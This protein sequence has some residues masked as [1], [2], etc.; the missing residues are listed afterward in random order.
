MISDPHEFY[1]FL[2]TPGIEVANLIFASDDVVWASWRFMEEKQISRLRHTNVGSY[3][4]GG[5]RLHMYSYLDRL[6]ERALYCET[7]SIMFVQPR[8]E[9]ALV[10]AGDN[11]GA[12]TSE[13]K[14]SQ[15]IEEYGSGGQKTM[16]TR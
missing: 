14:P 4:T 9:P 6:Q 1:G 15:F 16:P 13:M 12:I 2:A 3:V 8:D 5:A 10:E 11:L 7:D